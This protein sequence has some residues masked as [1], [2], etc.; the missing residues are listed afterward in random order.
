M[1]DAE[2]P[3]PS[4]VARLTPAQRF[5]H[6]LATGVNREGLVIAM[7]KVTLATN[8]LKEAVARIRTQ[9]GQDAPPTG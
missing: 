2:E 1:P 8:G 9:L 4:Y 6:R 5:G 7:N 3:A